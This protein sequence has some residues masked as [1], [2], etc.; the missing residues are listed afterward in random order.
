MS[1]CLRRL[2][3]ARVR[4]GAAL[5]I[6]FCVAAEL[7]PPTLLLFFICVFGKD[8]LCPRDDARNAERRFNAPGKLS[9]LKGLQ[10]ADEENQELMASVAE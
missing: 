7:A 8:W 3:N 1:S 10:A 4:V 9:E 6:S 2:G 5:G